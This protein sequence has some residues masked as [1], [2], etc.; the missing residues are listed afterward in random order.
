MLFRCKVL[1]KKSQV[2]AGMTP[3]P[4]QY[5][6]ILQWRWLHGSKSKCRTIFVEL[7]KLSWKIVSHFES[8]TMHPI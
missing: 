8:L 7:K 1:G 3:S 2:S 6:L 4:E 5:K